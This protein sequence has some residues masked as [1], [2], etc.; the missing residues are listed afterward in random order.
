MMLT[1]AAALLGAFLGLN[2]R[3]RVMAALVTA[4]LTG[5]AHLTLEVVSAVAVSLSAY[6]G[7]LLTLLAAVGVDD[8]GTDRSMAA[9]AMAALF[10]GLLV[11]VFERNGDQG[12]LYLPTLDDGRPRR[13]ARARS[14]RAQSPVRSTAALQRIG[15]VLE[16]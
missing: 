7:Q 9:G 15:D 10:A 12:G 6:P 14:R 4:A 1:V 8:G 3:N 16:G 13:K 2:S 5:A 11:T